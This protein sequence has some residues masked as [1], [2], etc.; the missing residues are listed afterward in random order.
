[1][2]PAKITRYLVLTSMTLLAFVA[3][4]VMQSKFEGADQRTSIGIVQ[5]TPSK[6]G[7]TVNDVLSAKHPGKLP[8]W[9]SATESSCFQHVRVRATVSPDPPVEPVNYDFV[10]DINGPSIHPG[11]PA[12]EE[13]LRLL[14]EPAAPA[15]ATT[16]AT[17]A[18]T[19]TP[20]ATA[21]T[22]SSSA[23]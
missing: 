12:G 2:E 19:E 13:V 11:N 18:T 23:R 16:T 21:A 4:V 15:T 9:S 17:P 8:I 22:A 7:R 20:A 3:I 1:M 10:V 6:S 14:N 5:L